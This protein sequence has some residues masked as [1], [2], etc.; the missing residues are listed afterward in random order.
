M[1][2]PSDNLAEETPLSKPCFTQNL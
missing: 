2:L 1:F